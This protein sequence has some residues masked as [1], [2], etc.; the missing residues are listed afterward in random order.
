MDDE[1]S[2]AGKLNASPKVSSNQQH[3]TLRDQIDAKAES[4]ERGKDRRIWGKIRFGHYVDLEGDTPMDFSD[5]KNSFN[6]LE[7]SPAPS[8]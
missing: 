5:P 2:N 4:G 8:K 7:D 3:D 6:R 1:E